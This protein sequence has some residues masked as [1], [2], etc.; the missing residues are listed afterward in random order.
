MTALK[1]IALCQCTKCL[2]YFARNRDPSSDYVIDHRCEECFPQQGIPLAKIR[3]TLTDPLSLEILALLGEECAEVQ[4]RNGKIVRWGWDADFEGTTQQHKLESELGDVLAA[5]LIAIKNGKVT[6]EGVLA[7]A[8]AKLE[9]FRV[10][11]A[12]PRQRL[13]HAKVPEASATVLIG[14]AALHWMQPGERALVLGEA[15]NLWCL[16]CG[17][18]APCPCENDE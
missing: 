16:G 2:R 9:K 7:A 6:F 10:D 15:R 14:A 17:D 4:Q 3:G 12:G 8:N 11:A 1:N 18:P 5:L 13:L